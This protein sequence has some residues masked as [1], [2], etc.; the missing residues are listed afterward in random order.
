M[1]IEG[2]VTPVLLHVMEMIGEVAYIPIEEALFLNE[3]EE[4]QAVK[5][6]GCVLFAFRLWREASNGSG[7]DS[8]FSFK[9]FIETPNDMFER[10]HDYSRL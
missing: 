6:G 7:E 1:A 10:C 2:V 8:R 5:Q 4:H 9:T 3:V